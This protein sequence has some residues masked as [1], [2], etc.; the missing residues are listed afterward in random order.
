MVGTVQEALSLPE[1][2][3]ARVCMG[4]DHGLMPSGFDF[5][6]A[7]FAVSQAELRGQSIAQQTSAG[8][9]GIVA[10]S[11][12]DF[13]YATALVTPRATHAHARRLGRT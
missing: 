2:G 9:Q 3:L 13:L 7:T 10:A 4:E 6:N 1:R 12:A 11:H 5:G 8:T